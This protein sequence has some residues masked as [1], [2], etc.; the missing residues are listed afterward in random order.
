MRDA[1][2]SQPLTVWNLH[3][4]RLREKDLE[5]NFKPD[6]KVYH[7]NKVGAYVSVF[8]ATWAPN[9]R[10]EEPFFTIGNMKRSLDIYDKKGRLISQ[11]N[12]GLSSVPAVT[13]AHPSLPVFVGGAA[14]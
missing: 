13:A 5:N 6:Y 9:V 11:H 7:D 4:N 2:L 12:Q 10:L 14:G 8:K 1:C 3:P